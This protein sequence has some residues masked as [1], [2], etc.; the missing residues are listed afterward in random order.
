MIHCP[1]GERWGVDTLLPYFRDQ[2]TTATISFI[3]G[4]AAATIRGQTL[5]KAAF[6]KREARKWIGAPVCTEKFQPWAV[7][8]QHN[9]PDKM[10]G[11]TKANTVVKDFAGHTSLAPRASTSNVITQLSGNMTNNLFSS[12]HA[13][14][15]S[16][17]VVELEG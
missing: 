15:E 3:M 12:L 1:G 5:I 8:Y 9:H 11:N 10:V 16:L 17:T 14:R 7:A 6:I 4:F 2:N 13:H